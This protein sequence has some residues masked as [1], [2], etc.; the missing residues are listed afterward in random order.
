LVAA[1]HV[2]AH[3]ENNSLRMPMTDPFVERSF[4]YMVEKVS[5]YAIFLLEVD[6]TIQTWNPAA[7]VMKGYTETEAIGCNFSMLY[8]TDARRENHPETNLRHA[9]EHGTFQEEAWRQ[10]KDGSLFWAM[11]EIIAIRDK[12]GALTGFC[13][14]TRDISHLK[15]LQKSLTFE[16]ERAEV[17]LGAVADGVMSVTESGQVEYLNYQA[18][19]ITG[20][21]HEDAKDL[22]VEQVFDI[23]QPTEYDTEEANLASAEVSAAPHRTMQVLRS[24]GGT[25]HIIETLRSTIDSRDDGAG[26]MVVV[27]R[28]VVERLRMQAALRDADRRK[29]EFL[30]MLAHEL[31]NPLAPVSAAA[32]LLALGKLDAASAKRASQVIIRQTKHMTELIDDLLDVSR[33]SRG[34]I[35]L[36]MTSLDMKIVVG[37]AI[38]QIR[39]LIESRHHTLAIQFTPTKA[40][41][42][43]D[44]RRLIQV[45]AN[46]LN[47]AAKYT[48]PGGTIGV[49]MSVT[50]SHVCVAVSDN[51]VGIEPAIQSIVFELFEQVQSTSDRTSGGLGIGLALARSLIRLH[52][53]TVTCHSDG[54][55]RGSRFTAYIP[56]LP[57]DE[58]VP[59]RRSVE[60]LIDV[61][62]ADTRLS[63][64]VVDDNT[65][66][67][68]MLQFF[69][70][71]AGH[72][73]MLAHTAKAALDIVKASTPDVCI[74]DLGLPDSDGRVLA[75]DIRKMV[76]PAPLLVALTGLDMGEDIAQIAE[77]GLDHY[78]V[79]P[80]DLDA[81][82]SV[83]AG[84]KRHRFTAN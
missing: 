25:R 17:T 50:E 44:E 37:Y 73:V 8:T 54:L 67:A 3:C 35:A 18:Q 19:L 80:A 4:S 78:F 16:K 33:V 60:R 52:G 45:F 6:G 21:S 10:R 62:V 13:K 26:G 15:D 83:V 41:V 31:R 29:N 30:A 9:A 39:P 47:N 11:V 20:W 76:S 82:A 55:G 81:L 77:S 58:Q 49:E 59:E 74:L 27:F 34:Q 1:H 7:A 53:G 65:D 42:R 24:R 56:R 71:A 75:Q 12:G 22:P 14:L 40:H 66:A 63:V 28:D 70:E 64:L 43:G 51:G 46:L 48:P 69:L 79:K 61:P 68:E 57:A 38:E 72:E 23:V 36:T 2:L 5:D 84:A 32:E